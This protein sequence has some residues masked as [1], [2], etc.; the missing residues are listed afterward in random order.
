[1][2]HFDTAQDLPVAMVRVP[3]FRISAGLFWDASVAVD[4]AHP[5]HGMAR[6]RSLDGRVLAPASSLLALR[7]FC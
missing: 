3:C 4:Q 6:H 5:P 7:V 1:M 2:H